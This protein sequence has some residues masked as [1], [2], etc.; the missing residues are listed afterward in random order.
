MKSGINAVALFADDS[1]EEVSGKESLIGIYP[2]SVEVPAI[3]GAI[4]KLVI[5]FRVHIPIEA[6]FNLIS[7]KLRRPDGEENSLGEV[8]WE[9]IV[10]PR[11]QSIKAGGTMV[12]LVLKAM[13]SPFVFKEEGRFR[14]VVDIDGEEVICGSLDGK[15][16]RSAPA[17]EPEL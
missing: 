6:K 1:R 5:Y 2:D 4:P 12:G 3:P 15:L 16:V 11:Q 7:A 10:E 8:T 17:S 9:N 14:A 13:I